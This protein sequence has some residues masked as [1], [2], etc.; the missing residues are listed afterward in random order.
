MRTH[1]ITHNTRWNLRDAV[2]HLRASD[3]KL[4]QLIQ[5]IGPP[6]LRREPDAWRALSS[7][8]IGQQVSVHAARAIRNRFAALA[9]NKDFPSPADVLILPD[10]TLRGAGLSANKTLSLRDLARHFEDG[11][12]SARKL[13]KLSDE[14]VIQTLIPVRGIGRWTAEMFLI[15]SLK[16][17]DVWAIDDLGLQNAVRKIYELPDHSSTQ[18]KTQ[19]L[20]IALPW[21]PYRSLASWYLWR[22][23]DNEPKVAK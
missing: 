17:S 6:K 4:N 9:E 5:R 18:L 15:F 23:L 14:D 22:S 19:M 20:E 13:N 2:A 16:R 10:E 3:E 7:S 8:I 21:R 1:S 11:K 12:I